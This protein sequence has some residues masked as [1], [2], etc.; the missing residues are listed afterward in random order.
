MG[1]STTKWTCGIKMDSAAL[2]TALPIPPLIFLTLSKQPKQSNRIGNTNP[3]DQEN[4]II[5]ERLAH[6][7]P[8]RVL[9][10]HET[11]N[12]RKDSL[13]GEWGHIERSNA[14]TH[15][16]AGSA[17]VVYAIVRP[18]AFP[19]TTYT[20]ILAQ[21]SVIVTAF[22]FFA[23][24]AFHVFSPV[25][26]LST[27]VRN[28][29]HLM[30][31]LSIATAALADTALA[32]RDFEAVPVQTA[33]DSILAALV[34]SV[35]FS[36]RRIIL[37]Q[38]ETRDLAFDTECSLDLFRVQHSDLEHAALRIASVGAL[39]LYW[40][41]IVPSLYTRLPEDVANVW[42]VGAVMGTTLLALGVVL[43]HSNLLD[44]LFV[45]GFCKREN[46]PCV[47]PALGCAMHS[48]AWWHIA[49]FVGTIVVVVAREYGI[50]AL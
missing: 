30:I 5:D 46:N 19:I 41:H 13:V 44:M 15:I 9:F 49:S 27:A 2:K 8:W 28:M 24:V 45:N 42:L 37:P 3:C 21:T 6:E 35:Y 31:Y 48:H 1:Q 10:R 50:A 39:T 34:L 11:S 23:S 20:S 22:M 7:A 33:V 18:F 4:Y 38:N 47:Y 32:T 29:D 17:Y 14:W 16:A 43:D 12:Q 25:S 36:L 26:T 40:I